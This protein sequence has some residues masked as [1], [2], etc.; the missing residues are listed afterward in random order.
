MH[1][2]HDEIAK[3]NKRFDDLEQA[4]S[5]RERKH[6]QA[7]KQFGVQM[8][9]ISDQNKRQFQMLEPMYKIFV[10]IQGFSSITMWILKAL[11][12]IGAGF[13]VIYGAIKWLK[14]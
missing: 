9:E 2:S 1:M 14:A 11:I 4:A 3:L 12:L 5:E 7:H 10:P 6:D 13:G 8:K